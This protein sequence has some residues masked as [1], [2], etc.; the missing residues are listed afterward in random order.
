MLRRAKQT[1]RQI[2]EQLNR[3]LLGEQESPKPFKVKI[4]NGQSWYKKLVGKEFMVTDPCN[5]QVQGTAL[6]GTEWCKF[7]KINN[8]NDID[9]QYLPNP[10]SD[11]YYFLRD[12]TSVLTDSVKQPTQVTPATPATPAVPATAETP[13]P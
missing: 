9:K 11:Q 8:I 3:R 6:K 1:K 10:D 2:I 5:D 13:T 4:T 12:D 7:Y